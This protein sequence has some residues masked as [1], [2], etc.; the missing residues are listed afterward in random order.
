MHAQQT[1]ATT[2]R[3]SPPVIEGIVTAALAVLAFTYWGGTEALGAH[4]FWGLNIA[5]FAIAAG[6]V[7]TLLVNAIRQPRALQLVIFGTLLI[8]SIAITAY[9]KTQFAASYAEDD[10]AGKLWFF[11]WISALTAVFGAIT[12]LYITR[13]RKTTDFQTR[14]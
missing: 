7:L 11:G 5:Y 3:L 10:F 13:R 8:I 1:P 2:P 4:P 14:A 12:T 9:G 6:V